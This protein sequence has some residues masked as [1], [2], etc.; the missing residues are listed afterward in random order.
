[1]P[2]PFVRKFTL[3]QR[4]F[5]R[6]ERMNSSRKKQRFWQTKLQD[7]HASPRGYHQQRAG[8]ATNFGQWCI[9]RCRPISYVWN[10]RLL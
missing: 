4:P 3:L 2:F 6:F 10:N 5:R 8:N 1:M 9:V 7:F